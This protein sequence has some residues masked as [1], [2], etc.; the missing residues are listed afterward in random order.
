LLIFDLTQAFSSKKFVMKAEC[1][2]VYDT[3]LGSKI[4]DV[5]FSIRHEWISLAL[6][7]ITGHQT[8]NMLDLDYASLKRFI[9]QFVFSELE[10]SIRHTGMHKDRIGVNLLDIVLLVEHVATQ[11][12]QPCIF[13]KV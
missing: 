4:C 13:R 8:S 9:Q 1:D 2:P 3:G 11:Y 12:V 5:L 6:E 10:R 7:V